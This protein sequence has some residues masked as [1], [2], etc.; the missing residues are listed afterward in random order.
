[1]TRRASRYESGFRKGYR[2]GLSAEMEKMP[3][4]TMALC[5]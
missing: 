1:M 3:D 4:T 5:G 2:K